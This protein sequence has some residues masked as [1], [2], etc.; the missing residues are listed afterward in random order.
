MTHNGEAAA[1]RAV[2]KDRSMQG[3]EISLLANRASFAAYKRARSSASVVDM[4]TISCLL[5][6]YN[7]IPLNNFMINA[8]KL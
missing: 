2:C 1:W 3:E 5:V 4:V 8:Y 7:V 6:H